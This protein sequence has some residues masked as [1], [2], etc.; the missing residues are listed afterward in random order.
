MLVFVTI[1][2]KLTL[3]ILGFKELLH[4]FAILPGEGG[5]VSGN[6][7][8]EESSSKPLSLDA[9]AAALHPSVLGVLL[10]MCSRVRQSPPCF[11]SPCAGT[12]ERLHAKRNLF[13]MNGI[14]KLSRMS[15]FILFFLI[16]LGIF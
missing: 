8:C 14:L 3:N 15:E 4:H 5:C 13:L 2:S 10:V 12:G 6:P 9:E 16:F 11:A 7:I 1:S